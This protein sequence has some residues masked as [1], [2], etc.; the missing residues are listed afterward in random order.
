MHCIEI[1][2]GIPSEPQTML[3]LSALIKDQ[4]NSER[5][6][7]LLIFTCTS[8][9]FAKS[10]QVLLMPY[11]ANLSPKLSIDNKILTVAF[12]LENAVIS[13]EVLL[14]VN[15]G[16]NLEELKNNFVVNA[17][18]SLRIKLE[19]Q[20]IGEIMSLLKIG[21]LNIENCL[22]SAQLDPEDIP[23]YVVSYLQNLFEGYSKY[24][25][26]FEAIRPF[27]QSTEVLI[28]G[29]IGGLCLEGSLRY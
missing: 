1:V 23:P 12:L 10:L 16:M 4:E 22:I 2:S 26:V 11:F 20:N 13:E 28:R 5:N 14:E 8:S 15:F 27:L 7:I 9:V 19:C 3:H 29:Y 18:E 6:E 21:D 17:L 25:D 24:F